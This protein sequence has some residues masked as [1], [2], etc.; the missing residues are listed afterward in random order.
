[1]KK[2]S[3]LL[4]SILLVLFPTRVSAA[5]QNICTPDI[6]V[7]GIVTVKG[8]CIKTDPLPAPLPPVPTIKPDPVVIPV[9][10]LPPIPTL[11]PVLPT[12]K[13]TKSSSNPPNTQGTSTGSNGGGTKTSKP[14]TNKPTAAQRIAA[15]ER[16]E[17]IEKQKRA[18]AL[19]QKKEQEKQEAQE[20]RQRVVN[21]AF[22]ILATLAFLGLMYLLFYRQKRDRKHGL[23]NDDYDL[24]GRAM[25]L[26]ID[27]LRTPPDGWK[28]A[29]TSLEAIKI[30]EEYDIEEVSF[31]HDLGGDDT[32]RTIVAW[33]C[34]NPIYWPKVCR[35]HTRNPV[36]DEW[37]RGMIERYG[38]GV[39][40]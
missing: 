31:D 10:T 32:T 28:W 21:V 35:V 1:M 24:Q 15:Q 38:P 29:K 26:W 2:V 13:P 33:L 19:A 11:P 40:K 22:I 34:N 6:V 18:K 23:D 9:P 17:A 16:R 39:T 4:I 27:D 8:T 36:G 14:K 5:Q 7:N 30:L 25:K 20:H 12:P 37:L 3:A